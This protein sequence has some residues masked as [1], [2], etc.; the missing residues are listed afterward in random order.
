GRASGPGP[1][2]CW[3]ARA[4]GPRKSDDGGPRRGGRNSEEVSEKAPRPPLR[5]PQR[6]GAG[7]RALPA[8]RAGGGRPAVGVVSGA[9]APAAEQGPGAGGGAG[10]AG[11]GRG[12]GGGGGGAGRG[13][14]ATGGPPGPTTRR[15]PAGRRKG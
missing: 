14:E 6:A 7:R 15:V 12:C 1:P 8:R 10:A 2:R 5:A 13:G 4:C 11:P 3:G 9:E